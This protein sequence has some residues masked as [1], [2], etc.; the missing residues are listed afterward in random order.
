MMDYV[1]EAVGGS[2]L[3]VVIHAHQ[4]QV[5]KRQA[6]ASEDLDRSK[7]AKT[8]L[9]AEASN[10]HPDRLSLLGLPLEIRIS[11]YGFVFASLPDPIH[12]HMRDAEISA[13]FQ[14]CSSVR[15]EMLREVHSRIANAAKTSLAG[16]SKERFPD[17]VDHEPYEEWRKVWTNAR[18]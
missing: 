5:M 17:A 16:R 7:A 8:D 1:L 14:I 13:L 2:A 12:E 15:A 10:G 3:F 9:S 6:D 4:C 11:I 18:K